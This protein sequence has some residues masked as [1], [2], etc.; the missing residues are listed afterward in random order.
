MGDETIKSTH[1]KVS[2]VKRVHEAAVKYRNNQE[3]ERQSIW[4]KLLRYLYGG[5]ASSDWSMT[6]LNKESPIALDHQQFKDLLRAMR[7]NC[8]IED[9]DLLEAISYSLRI[10]NPENVPQKPALPINFLKVTPLPDE[11]NPKKDSQR[12]NR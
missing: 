6:P 9:T 5:R 12:Q 8:E 4:G 1:T 11:E 7:D 2:L 10:I 3:H